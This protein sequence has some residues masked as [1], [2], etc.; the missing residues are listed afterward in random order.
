MKYFLALLLGLLPALA[1]AA[2]INWTWTD[3]MWEDGTPIPAGTPVAYKVY[4]A[5]KGQP[6]VLLTTTA[7]TTLGY[8]QKGVTL[9]EWC[10]EVTAIANALESNRSAEG[11]ATISFPRPAAPTGVNGA[12]VP[13]LP[14]AF[15]II[16]AQDS[17][18][19]LPVGTVGTNA[20]CDVSQAVSLRGQTYSP[21]P[22]AAV[23]FT[24]TARPIVAFAICG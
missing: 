24:G 14:T 12:V 18:V 9:G 13:V 3:R 23:R 7:V 2:D 22:I 6:K 19:M 11:C 17:L 21:V 5:A 4:G 8:T 20:V 15:T 16:K 10:I 1:L